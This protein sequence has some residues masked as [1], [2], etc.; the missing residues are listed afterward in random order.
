MYFIDNL[1]RIMKSKGITV[2][3]LEKEIGI[4]QSTYHGWENG[5]TPATD[6]L[7]EI[8]KF[9]EV[10]PNEVFGYETEYMTEDEKELISNFRKLPKKEQIKFIGK[11]ED[12]VEEI[13]KTKESEKGELSTLK[14]G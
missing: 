12:K 10:T 5:K 11:I 7:L 1:N 3:K 4:R 6:K 8:I 14:S 2:Y 9:L 13:I